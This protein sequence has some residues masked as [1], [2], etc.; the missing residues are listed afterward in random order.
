MRLRPPTRPTH[1]RRVIWKLVALIVVI[2]LVLLAPAIRDHARA[3]AVLEQLSDPNALPLLRKMVDYPVD[4]SETT[5]VTP[6]GP[7][8]ARLYTP[9]GVQHPPGL[10]LV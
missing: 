8:R 5:L 10:L 7:I 4:E 3:V 9:R 6:A 2:A 1:R